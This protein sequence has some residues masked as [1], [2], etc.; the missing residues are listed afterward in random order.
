MPPRRCLDSE[1]HFLFTPLVR[2]VLSRVREGDSLR[3]ASFATRNVPALRD[4][5]G[6][7]RGWTGSNPASGE[8]CYRITRDGDGSAPGLFPLFFF[9]EE[10]RRRVTLYEFF[11]CFV[12][13]RYISFVTHK[14]SSA[15][16]NIYATA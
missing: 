9:F 12:I 3:D 15:V 13:Y 7:G 2:A 8:R 6:G 14:R 5:G 4:L 1:F 11:S 16:C 10:S